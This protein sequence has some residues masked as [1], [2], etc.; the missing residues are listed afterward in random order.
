YYFL[1]LLVFYVLFNG[2]IRYKVGFVVILILKYLDMCINC[3]NF[4]K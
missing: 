3:I 1:R 4:V 2:Y